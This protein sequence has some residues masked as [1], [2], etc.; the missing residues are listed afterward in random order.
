MLNEIGVPLEVITPASTP[1]PADVLHLPTS[2]RKQMRN[3]RRVKIPA[4]RTI[5][6]CK[7]KLALTHA[8]GTGSF[9]NGAYLTDPIC[10]VSGLC[11]KSSMLAVGGDAGDNFP[12]LGITYIQEKQQKFACIMVFHGSDKYDNL[13]SLQQ[14]GLTPFTG[15]SSQFRDI[16]AVLQRIIDLMK[17]FLN[18][19]WPFLNTVLG[20][21]NHCA[22]HSLS[23]L[24]HL[25][26]QSSQSITVSQ[27]PSFSFT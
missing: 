19:D 23:D 2:T 8:T 20:L 12:K 5:I 24:L 11:L 1:S 3:V 17:A 4:E 14:P 16:F 9:A 6:K 21:K 13:H 25:I 26:E 22:T 15:D 10:F 18:G 27:F 7:K